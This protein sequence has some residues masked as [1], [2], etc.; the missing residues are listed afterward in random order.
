MDEAQ[1]TEMTDKCEIFGHW[2]EILRKT[3]QGLICQ[4]V[5]IAGRTHKKSPSPN[6]DVSI[7]HELRSA[8][9]VPDE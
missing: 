7:A 9:E 5:I 3:T 1:K 8:G 6:E 2:N 4:N